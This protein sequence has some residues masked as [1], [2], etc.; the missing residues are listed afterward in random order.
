MTS[1]PIYWT[2]AAL[3][4]AASALAVPGNAHHAFAAEFDR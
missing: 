4:V 3:A 2:G 1:K